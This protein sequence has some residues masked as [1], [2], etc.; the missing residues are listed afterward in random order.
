MITSNI[1]EVQA[2]IEQRLLSLDADINVALETELDAF[3]ERMQ[4]VTPV[5]TGRMKANYYVE[6][7][8]IESYDVSDLQEYTGVVIYGRPGA[9]DNPELQH[10]INEE[11]QIL[12]DLFEATV[13][14]AVRGW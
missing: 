14:T 6:Q 10:V 5:V 7:T 12:E 3:V 8:G 11:E 13:T 4:A 1:A 2:E 9:K